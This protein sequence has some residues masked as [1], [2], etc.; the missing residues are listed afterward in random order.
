[1][2]DVI[3]IRRLSHTAYRDKQQRESW[4]RTEQYGVFWEGKFPELRLR[5]LLD[6]AL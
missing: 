2:S 1:M 6:S 5:R 4:I 3:V